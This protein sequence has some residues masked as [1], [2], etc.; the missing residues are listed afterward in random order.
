MSHVASSASPTSASSILAQLVND[1]LVTVPMCTP[2]YSDAPG[3][4]KKALGDGSAKA[5]V[6]GVVIDQSIPSG[7]SGSVLAIGVVTASTAQWDAVCG[8]TGGLTYGTLYYLSTSVAGRL[9]S[10]A[11]SAVPVIFG[12]GPTVGAIV[13]A[14]SGGGGGGGGITNS[15]PANTLM[16]SNGANAVA[17]GLT[18]DGTMLATSRK[19]QIGPAAVPTLNHGFVSAGFATMTTQMY[20]QETDT[21]HTGQTGVN[22]EAINLVLDQKAT[23]NTTS[24]PVSASGN[25]LTVLVSSTR[26]TGASPLVNDGIIISVGGGQ[27]NRA[28]YVPTGGGIASLNDGILSGAITVSGDANFSGGKIVATFGT[29]SSIS[30]TGNI[31]ASGALTGGSAHVTGNIKG[32]QEWIIDPSGTHAYMYLAN[33][34]SGATVNHLNLS[35]AGAG[36]KIIINGNNV[37]SNSGTGGIEVWGG[38]NGGVAK[39]GIT[40]AGITWGVSVAV[41]SPTG[42]KWTTGTVAPNGSVTGNVGDEYTNT[43]TGIKYLKQS[44]AGTN[45]GW[46]V[47]GSAAAG[48]GGLVTATAGT[49]TT[50]SSTAVSQANGV[51]VWGFDS[52]SHLL[53]PVVYQA[54]ITDGVSFT[55]THATATTAHKFYW[56]A[57]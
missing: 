21:N 1:E 52:A 8:T 49:S 13:L 28:I 2:V 24:D 7:K 17:S 54:S 3:G 11:T 33:A 43:A 23:F 26:A 40:G 9:T 4:F 29:G 51:L 31:T 55:I 5:K 18:D 10:S 12:L 39:G 6:V 46:T 34:V 42:P 27:T 36:G 25:G 50:V 41:G 53:D 47:P 44:G 35:A 32:D 57:F 30:L 45:T 56:R 19:F 14:S 20:F 38:N 15:A 22:N 37:G 16:L 48:A